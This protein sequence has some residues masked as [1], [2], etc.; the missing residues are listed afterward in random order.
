MRNYDDH[1]RDAGGSL[2]KSTWVSMNTTSD[3][4]SVYGPLLQATEVEL[5]E[6]PRR[7]RSIQERGGVVHTSS[8]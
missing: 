1:V 2:S 7:V 6:R 4:W 5:G 8:G 3:R